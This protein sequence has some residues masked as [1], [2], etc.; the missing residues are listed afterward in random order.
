MKNFIKKYWLIIISLIYLVWPL[1]IVS[2]LLGPIGL[3]DDG[4]VL[5]TAI[6]NEAYKHHKAKKEAEKSDD[7]EN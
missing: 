1:D 3:I 7:S 5:L 6:A 2:E 4:A